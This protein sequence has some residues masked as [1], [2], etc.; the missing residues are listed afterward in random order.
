MNPAACQTGSVP[1]PTGQ[2]NTVT[3][4]ITYTPYASGSGGT[5]GMSFNGGAGSSGNVVTAQDSS[6]YV[7]HIHMHIFNL[8]PP[9]S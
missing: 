8:L 6:K 1:A 7:P 3:F 5:I 4:N 9:I 2:T